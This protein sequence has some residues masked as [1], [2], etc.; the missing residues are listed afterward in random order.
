MNFSK[1][2]SLTLLDFSFSLSF[3]WLPKLSF[4]LHFYVRRSVESS[5]CGLYSQ[6]EALYLEYFVIARTTSIESHSQICLVTL[7]FIRRCPFQ[8]ELQGGEF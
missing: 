7:V 2:C 3:I 1:Y 6:I 4:A 5:N 8:D